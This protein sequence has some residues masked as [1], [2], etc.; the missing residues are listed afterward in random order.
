M[1]V[2]YRAVPERLHPAL[3][4]GVR[5]RVASHRDSVDLLVGKKVLEISPALDWDK[6]RL[7]HRW[8]RGLPNGTLPFYFGDD[9]N[10][11]TI[12]HRVRA[13]GGVTVAVGALRSRAEFRVHS[14]LEVIWF[15]EWLAREWAVHTR[16]HGALRRPALRSG[17]LARVSPPV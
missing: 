5:R 11:E 7:L 8:M 9:T 4:A 3:Y 13:M 17:R 1:A 15:L 16:A 14:P 12:H 10:D 6:S 2:H